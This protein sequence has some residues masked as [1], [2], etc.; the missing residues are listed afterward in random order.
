MPKN[1]N[2]I[3]T[4][5][6]TNIE[7][8]QLS[9]DPDFSKVETN[10]QLLD[11]LLGSIQDFQNSREFFDLLKFMGRFT[12]YSPFNCA[13]LYIQNPKVTY[14]ATPAQW[15]N[16]H[17]RTVKP[18]SRPMVILAPMRPVMFVY[19]MVDTEGPPVPDYILNPF[20]VEGTLDEK[21]YRHTFHNA[22]ARGIGVGIEDHIS[23]LQ[24]GSAWRL[25]EPV[26]LRFTDRRGKQIGPI[27]FVIDINE[28]LDIPTRYDTVVHELAHIFCGHLGVIGDENWPQRKDVSEL[29]CEFEAE[30]VAYVVCSRLGISNRSTEYLALKAARNEKLPTISFDAIIRAVNDIEEMGKSLTPRA[31]E[32]MAQISQFPI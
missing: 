12:Q 30:A 26:N 24:A 29:S 7:Y 2:A 21:I 16:K 17:H 8:Q 25:P 27:S 11:D 28:A 1:R 15:R 9:F 31:R 10:K 23:V 20:Q 22:R 4:S 5:E 14:V 13:L 19:D 32:I 3:K 18:H 6:D